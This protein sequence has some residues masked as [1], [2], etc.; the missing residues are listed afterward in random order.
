MSGMLFGLAGKTLRVD[1]S[2]RKTVS[3]PS[4]DYF[5]FLGGRGVGSKILFDELNVNVSP[6]DPDNLLIFSPGL[7]VGTGA[8][9]ATRTNISSKNPDTDGI[10]FANVGGG[11]GSRLRKAG[12]DN[13]IFSGRASE[14]VFL[15]VSDGSAEI[16]RAGDLWGR[17]TYETEDR[18]RD[19]VGNSKVSVA[20][21]GP[22][23]ENLTFASAVIVDK[24]HAAGGCALASVMG[25]KN[26]KAVA[27]WGEREVEVADPARL[28]ELRQEI[29]RRILATEHSRLQRKVGSYGRAIPSFQV[30]SMLP[31]RN[32]EDDHWEDEKVR[33]L[34]D[35]DRYRRGMIPCDES[36]CE[37]CMH[38]L[39]LREG[40][41]AGTTCVGLQAN[42]GYGFG[43][44]FD[45]NDPEVVI[46]ATAVCN[47]LGIDID[48]ASTI[49]SWAFELFEKGL[50][51]RDDTGGVELRWGGGES[52]LALLRDLALRRGFGNVLADGFKSASQR[53]GRGSGYYAMQVKGQGII[54]SVRTA[55]AWG[56][57]HMVSTRG[58]RHLDGS[59][60][61]EARDFPPEVMERLFGV[62][63]PIGQTNYEGKA[64]LVF[65]FE[66]YK[67]LT[68]CLGVCYFSSYWG[69]IEKWGPQDYAAML[70]AVTGVEMSG[71]E[72]LR[73]GW[74]VHELEKAFNTIHAGFGRRDDVPPARV[75]DEPVKTGK[76]RGQRLNYER[77]N[78]MLSEYYELHGWDRESGRQRREM[79]GKL[80]L[81]NV[82]E[83]L[84]K[85]GKIGR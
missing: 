59:P 62:S 2:R 70:K 65:W 39:E 43:P 37:A 52:L 36:C 28:E 29:V 38:D 40:V 60:T 73:L 81:R 66:N 7:F 13:L 10:G 75:F 21:I 26:L 23:G 67:A 8:P 47:D 56:F 53:I 14:P 57:G 61:I 17:G 41:Y 50:I 30:R 49:I 9:Q 84:E 45:V 71:E 82:S 74:K 63:T 24:G 83:M 1:L 72:L 85:Y 44:R 77:Y 4:S 76:L 68:D 69:T 16:R 33:R 6:Y 25:S 32:Y 51:T 27:A 31:V 54:D 35:I 58:A 34:L 78:E 20:S 19:E 80:G 64:R 15:W 46:R 3:E 11:F 48:N 5:E 18:I 42:S 12:F 79:L 22:A 55:I